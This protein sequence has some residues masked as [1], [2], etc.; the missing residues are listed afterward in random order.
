MTHPVDPW[1]AFAVTTES[2]PSG[3]PTPTPGLTPAPSQHPS[4]PAHLPSPSPGP[5]PVPPPPVWGGDP[6]VGVSP[7]Y[8]RSR[9]DACDEGA[10]LVRIS[11]AAAEDADR[12]L[13]RQ[14]DGWTF[15]KSLHD[16]QSRWEALNKLI[17]GRL[18][19]A[20]GNFRDSADAF[21]ENETATESAFGGFPN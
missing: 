1:S 17:V 11:R 3:S 9:A 19:Q 13:A 15:I 5:S 10:D 18:D 8:L 6:D 16:M 20:A 7:A 2:G 4:P 14:D 12:E 21:D